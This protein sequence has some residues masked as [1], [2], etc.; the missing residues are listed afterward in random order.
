MEH[1]NTS[2]SFVDPYPFCWQQIQNKHI[3]PKPCQLFLIDYV[4]K[5]I[6]YFRFIY[7]THC[8]VFLGLVLQ[9]SM[10]QPALHFSLQM[11]DIGLWI[12]QRIS[13]LSECEETTVLALCQR[14]LQWGRDTVY[15]KVSMLCSWSW[16]ILSHNN[17]WTISLVANPAN[18]V[19]LQLKQLV[20]TIQ[21]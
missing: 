8:L 3:F 10:Q 15:A 12:L 5:Q 1:T 20:V 21:W 6:I 17:T 18:Q 14:P 11:F 19:Q 16:P 7:Y 13:L 4:K 9:C 2:Q